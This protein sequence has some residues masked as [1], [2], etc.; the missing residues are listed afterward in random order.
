MFPQN[1]VVSDF[2]AF[3][4]LTMQIKNTLDQ[5][6]LNIICHSSLTQAALSRTKWLTTII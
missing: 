4:I 2:S 3:I 6:M 1:A 5:L